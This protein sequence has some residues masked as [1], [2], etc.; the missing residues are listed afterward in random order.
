M[1][2]RLYGRNHYLSDRLVL[3]EV[4]KYTHIKLSWREGKK[5]GREIGGSIN[6]HPLGALREVLSFLSKVWS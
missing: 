5:K 6:G 4:F 3:I 1:L 2:V